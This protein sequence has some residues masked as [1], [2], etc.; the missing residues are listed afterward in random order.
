M[1]M[2]SSYRKGKDLNKALIQP[3]TTP[4]FKKK[5]AP[6]AHEDFLF[7]FRPDWI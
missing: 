7:D 5:F 1:P 4:P 3:K 6:G 2:M